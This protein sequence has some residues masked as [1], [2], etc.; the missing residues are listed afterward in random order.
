MGFF[1]MYKHGLEKVWNWIHFIFG[2][3]EKSGNTT[4]TTTTTT[5][6]TTTT[7]TKSKAFI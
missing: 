4:T 1:R 6:T 7:T 5:A 3:L 2:S